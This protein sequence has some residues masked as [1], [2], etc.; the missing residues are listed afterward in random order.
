MLLH[1][2]GHASVARRYGIKT[3]EIIMFP[4][5]GVARLARNPKPHEEFWIALAGPAVNV[6]IAIALGSW[7]V[8][9]NHSLDLG[10]VLNPTDEN[11]LTRIAYGNLILAGFNM[12]PAF[13][14]DGGRVLRAALA[15]YRGEQQ[16]TRLAAAAG[17][18][19][20][21]LMGLYGLVNA[22]FLLL[23]IALFVYIAASQETAVVVGRELTQ[24]YR[25]EPR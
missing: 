15:R 10:A 24:V 5:G 9:S 2:L 4:I 16:A 14:M 8:Y 21:V 11:L 1:E 17:R 6:L 22:Q 25:S 13:P 3:V 12:I 20:A 23:F 18:I 19:F 7:L